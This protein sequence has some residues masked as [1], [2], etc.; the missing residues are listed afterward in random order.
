MPITQATIVVNRNRSR[1]KQRRFD[2][3]YNSLLWLVSIL[4]CVMLLPIFVGM[5][6]T[7]QRNIAEG[8]D[9]LVNCPSLVD[10][11]VVSQ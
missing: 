4:G 2:D 8:R 3:D 5:G 11:T 6:L 10:V 9:G 1:Q 7:W